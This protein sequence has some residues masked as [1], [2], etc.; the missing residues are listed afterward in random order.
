MRENIPSPSST[1]P[2]IIKET[3]KSIKKKQIRMEGREL[4]KGG[5][6]LFNE[7]VTYVA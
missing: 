4:F 5:L 6:F 3:L 7:V 1:N 2:G